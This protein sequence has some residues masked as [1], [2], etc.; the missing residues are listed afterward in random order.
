MILSYLVKSI[1]TPLRLILALLL[2]PDI[3][4]AKQAD[5]HTAL[6]Q[7]YTS[8]VGNQLIISRLSTDI[9]KTQ[10]VHTTYHRPLELELSLA[11]TQTRLTPDVRAVTSPT[12]R[13]D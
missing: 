10:S 6:S 3:W 9:K 2:S 5:K 7:P 13:Y 4:Q 1:E 11:L 8:G 12:L